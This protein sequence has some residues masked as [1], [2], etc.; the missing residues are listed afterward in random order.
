MQTLWSGFSSEAKAAIIAAIVAAIL[1]PI[2]AKSL[3]LWG[4][5]NYWFYTHTLELL[6]SAAEKLDADFERS[7][8]GLI[9]V[10][11]ANYEDRL[12]Q[13]AKAAGIS[14]RRAKFAISWRDRRK[15]YGKP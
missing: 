12:P 14:V 1:G 3:N 9:L 4:H 15:K 2:V 11:K 8:P 10:E 7:H 5:V 13:L 6:E